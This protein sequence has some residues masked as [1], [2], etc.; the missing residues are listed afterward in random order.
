M[1][2]PSALRFGAR[3]ISVKLVATKT[4]RGSTKGCAS[5]DRRGLVSGRTELCA[6][7]QCV[8]L[9]VR[10]RLHLRRRGLRQEDGQVDAIEGKRGCGNLALVDEPS[11]VREHRRRGEAQNGSRGAKAKLCEMRSPVRHSAPRS[12]EISDPIRDAN[13][14]SNYGR[15]VGAGDH[16]R[17]RPMTATCQT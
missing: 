16:G 7:G 8:R 4:A 3:T 12:E 2:L 14:Q 9:R 6:A 15:R 13:R 11:S 1:A 17:D 5:R 10:G